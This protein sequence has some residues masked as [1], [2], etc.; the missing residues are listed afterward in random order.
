MEKA[1]TPRCVHIQTKINAS[2]IT[3]YNWVSMHSSLGAFLE[4]WQVD[5]SAYIQLKSKTLFHSLSTW[6]ECAPSCTHHLSTEK[7]NTSQ[8]QICLWLG[9]EINIS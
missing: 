1:V 6:N 4:H 2:Q 5:V 9:P 7:K 8:R 3:Y